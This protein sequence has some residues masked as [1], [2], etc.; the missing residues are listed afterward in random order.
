[1]MT[2]KNEREMKNNTEWWRNTELKLLKKKENWMRT[3]EDERERK[4]NTGRR[5]N[6]ELS[7]KGERTS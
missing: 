3:K 2:R 4:K 1:M 5:R 7:F 6:K